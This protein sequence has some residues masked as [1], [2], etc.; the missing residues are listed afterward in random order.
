[1]NKEEQLK[2][3][4]DQRIEKHKEKKNLSD[5]VIVD[6]CKQIKTMIETKGWENLKSYV[7]EQYEKMKD[8]NM[9]GPSL[10]ANFYKEVSTKIWSIE[11]K[12]Q[13]TNQ[14]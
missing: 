9:N 1:M 4:C 10:L 14:K 13:A 8:S 3:W 5:Q 12:C 6:G 7:K 11:R 2:E